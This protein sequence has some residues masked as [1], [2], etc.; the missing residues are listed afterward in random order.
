MKNKYFTIRLK[1]D[2]LTIDFEHFD[3]TVTSPE[4]IETNSLAKLRNSGH[5]FSPLLAKTGN[6]RFFSVKKVPDE[7][8]PDSMIEIFPRQRNQEKKKHEWKK[9]GKTFTIP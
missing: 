2:I 3:K 6:Y 5:L 7:K 9:G 1:L 8:E 4:T